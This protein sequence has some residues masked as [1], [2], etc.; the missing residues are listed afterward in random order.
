MPVIDD[1]NVRFG[2]EPEILRLRQNPD[3]CF[4]L[5]TGN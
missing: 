2:P 5:K 1:V 4:A 3:V